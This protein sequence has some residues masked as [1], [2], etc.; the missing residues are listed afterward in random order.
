MRVP[1]NSPAWLGSASASKWSLELPPTPG[2]SRRAAQLERERAAIETRPCGSELSGRA[3]RPLLRRSEG[4][5]ADHVIEAEDE[6]AAERTAWVVSSQAKLIPEPDVTC[7]SPSTEYAPRRHQG[8]SAGGRP[9]P[10]GLA[11]ARWGSR[12]LPRTSAV[13]RRREAVPEGRSNSDLT[14]MTMRRTP[15]MCQTARASAEMRPER[16]NG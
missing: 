7:L 16:A 13:W 12:A 5:I 8:C 14:R 15:V 6:V 2:P 10:R 4:L 1:A 3:Q 9:G 11:R